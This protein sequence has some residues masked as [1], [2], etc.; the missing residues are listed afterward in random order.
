M[1]SFRRFSILWLALLLTCSAALGEMT[2]TKK[3]KGF[4]DASLSAENGCLS[5]AFT[6]PDYRYLTLK[7]KTGTESGTVVIE[8][9]RD[10]L[11][12]A[13]RFCI[14]KPRKAPR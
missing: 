10:G 14:Q 12:A 7:Y 11:R 4:S 6:A 9:G 2:V 1:K 5:Y 8:G 3:N 13:S